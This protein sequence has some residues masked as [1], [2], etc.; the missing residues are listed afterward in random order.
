[1]IEQQQE[2]KIPKNSVTSLNLTL[3]EKAKQLK[4]PDKAL[5]MK[6]EE[7]AVEMYDQEYSHEDDKVDKKTR[8]KVKG[9]CD[10]DK[11]EHWQR[12]LEKTLRRRI[13]RSREKQADQEYIV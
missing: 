6:C 3:V 10:H 2:T 13:V 5:A 12:V 9:L 11:L 4:N 8:V 1:M 7:M